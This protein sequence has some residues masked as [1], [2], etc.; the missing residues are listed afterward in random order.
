MKTK[1]EV[2]SRIHVRVLPP[3]LMR[4]ETA[5]DY[6]EAGDGWCFEICEQDSKE[7][8]FAILIHELW[9]WFRTQQAGIKEED[10]M[11]FDIANPD[12]DEP[13]DLPE[14]P[15]HKEHMEATEVERWAIAKLGL[16]W[17]PYN[18]SIKIG[19]KV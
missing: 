13:G 6:Y 16:D 7:A 11:A 2:L 17:E 15:Y 3:E 1:L 9:E 18:N 5:G 19:H 14:A 10:I 8:E 4:Y 12:A